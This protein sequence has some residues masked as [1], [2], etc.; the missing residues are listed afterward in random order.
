MH[1]EI[2]ALQESP[3]TAGKLEQQG[4]LLVKM[5]PAEFGKYM[6]EEAA[7]WQ[8]VIDKAGIKGE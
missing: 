2:T 7:R 3:G 5:S 1:G 6:Q 8:M 4:A